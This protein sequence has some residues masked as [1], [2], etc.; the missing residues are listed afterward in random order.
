MVIERTYE[1][2]GTTFGQSQVI[3]QAC[4]TYDD[5]TGYLINISCYMQEE[6]AADIQYRYGDLS[7]DEMPDQIYGTG[8]I[9]YEY[10]GLGR[11]TSFSGQMRPHLCLSRYRRH[12]PN[13]DL[14]QNL[15]Q[16]N[17]T[18]C[19]YDVNGNIIREI[20]YVG[21]IDNVHFLINILLLILSSKV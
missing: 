2:T 19:T 8:A 11:I 18:E 10:D 5:K 13:N 1:T 14:R 6:R 4:Y 16:I 15:H 9:H 3:S 21:T 12:Q 20:A 17:T 7:K